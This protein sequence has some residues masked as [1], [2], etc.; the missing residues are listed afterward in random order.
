MIFIGIILPT[1][2]E[3]YIATRTAAARV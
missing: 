1:Q 3:G 2:G